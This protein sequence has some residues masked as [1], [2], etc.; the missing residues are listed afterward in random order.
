MG[1]KNKCYL[2][3]RNIKISETI[4]GKCKCGNTYCQKHKCASV[5]DSDVTHKCSYDYKQEGKKELTTQ[6]Q[7]VSNDKILK[8]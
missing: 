7:K 1:D 2:C 5:E 6:L 4:S 8:I 3:Q